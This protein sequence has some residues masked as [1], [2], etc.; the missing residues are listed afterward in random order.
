MNSQDL[1]RAWVDEAPYLLV[2]N[3]LMTHDAECG[4]NFATADEGFLRRVEMWK[5]DGMPWDMRDEAQ[6]IAMFKL[7]F[8]D[9]VKDRLHNDSSGKEAQTA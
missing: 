6:R 8:W 5:E 3:T 2:Y 1:K 7:L 9:L 4:T